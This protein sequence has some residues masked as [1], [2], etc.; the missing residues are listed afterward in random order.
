[1]AIYK[2][3]EAYVQPSTASPMIDVPRVESEVRTASTR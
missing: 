2:R 1:M 3:G